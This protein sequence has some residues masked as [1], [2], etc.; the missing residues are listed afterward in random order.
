MITHRHAG[1]VYAVD[2][3]YVQPLF[4]AVHLVVEG[5]RAAIVDCGTAHSVPAILQALDELAVPPAAVDWLLLTHV[6]LDHAGGAGQ[7][8]R[9]LPNAV[10]VV[11]PRGAPHLV[12]PQKLIDAS[13]AVYG[14]E[15]YDALY[16]EILPIDAARVRASAEGEILSLGA[17]RFE[18]MHTPGHALHHQVF[19]DDATNAVFTGDTFGLAYEA[20]AVGS[21][22]FAVPTTSPSQFDPQ[23]LI[24]SIGRIL[25]RKPAAAF[26]THYSRIT[27]LE[28][29]G[30][31]LVRMIEAHVA[32]ALAHAELPPDAARAAIRR[33]LAEIFDHEL[34]RFGCTAPAELIE[35][36]LGGDIEL[37]TDGLLAWLARRRR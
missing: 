8:M 4:D 36:W 33:D 26:L 20:L 11:H 34:H 14:R 21:R 35:R 28:R 37:N 29:V 15:T 9:A 30:A 18:V 19:F 25:A 31:D 2:A 23:Q 3:E 24:E 1:G 5:G 7:L 32:A 16:G 27:D 6:H 17:R 22:A 13:I 12:D 10:A